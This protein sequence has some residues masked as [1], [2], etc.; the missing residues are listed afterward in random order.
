MSGCR[1]HPA[2]SGFSPPPSNAPAGHTQ[3]RCRGRSKAAPAS[4]QQ[5]CDLA[6]EAG[7]GGREGAQ[8]R[9][10]SPSSESALPCVCVFPFWIR[11][12]GTGISSRPVF[13]PCPLAE[14]LCRQSEP[15]PEA[16]PL[17][18]CL[19]FFSS[20]ALTC[21]RTFLRYPPLAS[22]T[23]P[24]PTP[25]S[26][27]SGVALCSLGCPGHRDERG[28]VQPAHQHVFL[29]CAAES[30]QQRAPPP[31]PLLLLCNGR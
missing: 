20:A 31:S 18:L 14:D 29:H 30:H 19:L 25:P 27:P 24:L 23:F 17:L 15:H 3:R 26:P 12:Y 9:R 13:S 6:G 16:H 7:G 5:R 11:R 28:A 10:V 1:S 8:V 4:V 21:P 22:L 2:A